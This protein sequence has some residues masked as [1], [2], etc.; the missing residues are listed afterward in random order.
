MTL[1]EHL[2]VDFVDLSETDLLD[3][4]RAAQDM[5]GGTAPYQRL[6]VRAAGRFLA[7]HRDLSMWMQRPLADRLVEISADS[8]TWPLLTFAMV[9][10]R[11][12]GDLELLLTKNFGH[13]MRRWVLGLYPDD[14]DALLAAAERI[15]T[16]RQGALGFIAEGLGLVISLTGRTPSELTTEDLDGCLQAIKASS[17]P[18]P[19]M[20]RRRSAAIFGLRKLL[21][22]AGLVDCPPARCREGGPATRQGRLA[23]INTTEVRDTLIAYLNAR[24]AVLRPKTI[25]KLT[26]ALAVFGEFLSTEFPDLGCISGL[27]RHHIEA[28]LAWSATR[29]CRGNHGNRPVGPFVTAHA[30]ISVRGFLEDI[31]AWG[32]PQAPAR[33]LVFAADIP[34]Q[35]TMLPRALPP[36]IDTALMDA[37]SNLADRFAR[38]GLT[39]LRGTGLRMGELLDLEL[40]AIVDYGPAGSWLRVPLGKLNN[41]RMVPLDAATLAAF[42]DWFAHR[43]HQRAHPH[44]R[45]GQPADFVFTEAGKRLGPARIQTGLRTAIIAAGI[46]GPDGNPQRIVAHQLRHTYATSLVNAGMSLQALMQLLGHVSPEMTMRYAHLASPTLR[47]AYDQAV[48]K[49]R[50][51]IPVSSTP[52]RTAMPDSV[53]WLHSEMLKTRVAHGYCSRDLAAE[54]CSYANICETCPNFTTTPEFIPAI[55]AQLDDIKTLRD[56]AEQRDWP[57]ETARHDRVIDSLQQ[58]LRRLENSTPEPTKD[59]R[60]PGPEDIVV[61]VPDAQPKQHP[62][63]AACVEAF[64]AGEHE[65]ADPVQRIFAAA[66]MPKRLVLDPTPDLVQTP[67]RDTDYVKRI[68]DTHRVIETAVQP[69]PV[70]LGQIRR[71]HLHTVEP[72]LGLRVEPFA[73][74]SALTALDQVDINRR[75]F[76]IRRQI[77]RL[78][79]PQLL[80]RTNPTRIIHER[81]AVLFHRSHHRGPTHTELIRELRHRPGVSADLTTRLN[82]GP[83]RQQTP[84]RERIS[85]LGPRPRLTRP[86]LTTPPPLRPLQPHR[87]AERGKIAALNRHPILSNGAHPTRRTTHHIRG[88]LY[89]DHHLGI[90]L[91]HIKNTET[92]QSQQGLSKAGSVTHRQGSPR[93]S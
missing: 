73:E 7:E 92:V 31:T 80:H 82:G 54:A 65:F 27:Q 34:K 45:T 52:G 71:H 84:T 35:P 49:L 30:A 32:W 59:F 6:R 19:A 33:Q 2:T 69:G 5:A 3:A 77:R 28:F 56:D 37:V 38:T 72:R 53:E 81:P 40:D 48:G 11:V 42:D 91:N 24:A 66:A 87:A 57:S 21:F 70:R 55:T 39:I 41:E 23:V 44:P 13:S 86:F 20:Q 83:P 8:H 22:E 93:N 58:H 25:A 43:Q 90:G 29:T 4:Y 74:V 36:D 14:T 88:R 10:T 64:A 17:V 51:R 79:D 1:T 16:S 78:I 76:T 47:A 9:S 67:I 26:S 61:G 89:L 75:M 46:R 60:Q 50:R 68:G 15:G 18:T 12:Q 62:L 63:C 85:G